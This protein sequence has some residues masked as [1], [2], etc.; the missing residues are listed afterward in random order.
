LRHLR[1]RLFS[2]QVEPANP[3]GVKVAKSLDLGRYCRSRQLVFSLVPR[4]HELYGLAK[5]TVRPR[6]VALPPH[7]YRGCHGC[8]VCSRA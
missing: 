6:Q 1:G 4:S 3:A 2:C 5:Y 7:G 8:G